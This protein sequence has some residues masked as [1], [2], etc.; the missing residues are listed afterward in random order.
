MLEFIR[1]YPGLRTPQ[2]SESLEVPAKTLE[3]WIKRLREQ[4]KIEFR[5]STKT[6]GD[7]EL[8]E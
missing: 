7:W 6:G 8:K 1:S 2:I 3:R 4:G 5:G